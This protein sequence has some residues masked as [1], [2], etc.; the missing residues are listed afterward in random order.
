MPSPEE[1]VRFIHGELIEKLDLSRVNPADDALRREVRLV[2][3]RLC[4]SQEP[5]L[6]RLEGA[7]IISRV[8]D[9]TFGPQT[10]RPLAVEARGTIF[11][12]TNRPAAERIASFTSLCPLGSGS[13]LAGFQ[14]GP[15]KH[16][17]TSTVRLCRSRDAGATWQELPFRFETTWNGIPGSL[18]AAEM[19]EVSPG[20]VL[21][22]TTWFDRSDPA[23]PLLDPITEGVLHSKQLYT[24]SIDEGD[25]WSAWHELPTPGLTGCAM[26]GPPLLWHDGTIAFAFESFKEYDDPKPGRH[27]AW[28]MLSRDGGETF[29]DP[30][31]VAQHPQHTVYYWDQ[32]L[33]PAEAV[34]DYVAL[35]WTHD[36]EQKMDLPV[37][38]RRGALLGR[39]GS[40]IPQETTIPGQIA[41]PLLLPDGR[42]L[43]FVV[44]RN[45]RPGTMTLW[46]SSDGGATWPA[47]T[48]LVVHTHD[49]RA[50]L[51]QGADNIDFTQ[52]WEDMA[53]WSFGHPAIRLLPDGRVLLA[54]YAGAPGCLSIHWTRVRV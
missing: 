31:L 3:E 46:Q 16:A 25:T 50:V 12:A 30:Y 7:R 33:C 9:L 49:E 20:S 32:R 45:R 36:L 21:L 51:S 53:R 10:P 26:T 2:V 19:V 48:S 6:N 11:D 44:E 42:L 14:L 41:A 28:L 29:S 15:A 40:R 54:Y 18:A 8:L 17:P 1:L 34:G 35:F 37:H 22:F 5:L 47:D 24:Y 4:D 23:R 13:I 39:A 27:A 52:Y 38:L 43:A